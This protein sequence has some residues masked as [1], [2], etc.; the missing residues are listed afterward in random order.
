MKYL[1]RATLLTLTFYSCTATK[2][3]FQ[4]CS[5]FRSGR[6]FSNMYNESGLGHWTKL[7]YYITRSDSLEFVTSTQFVNDTTI[8]KVTWTGDCEYKLLLLNPKTKLDSLLITRH[9]TGINNTVVKATDDYFII[10]NYSDTKDTVWK[11]R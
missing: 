2:L 1:I 6:Y 8:Y 4:K 11:A 7:T 10:K 9:P 3:P 5:D